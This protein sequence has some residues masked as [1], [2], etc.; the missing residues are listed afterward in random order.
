[1][2]LHS[3]FEGIALGLVNKKGKVG[4][5]AVGF[6]IHKAAEAFSVGS[7]VGQYP[8]KLRI[9]IIGI[10]QTAL[11]TGVLLG[12][13]VSSSNKVVDSVFFSLSAGMLTYIACSEIIVHEFAKPELQPLKFILVGIGMIGVS[14][15]A[16]V[17]THDHGDGHSHG[18]H[19][20]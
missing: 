17:E 12:M 11:T 6:M 18:S 1:M 16:M 7:A 8:L 14:G 2:A 4:S 5:I 19:G 10:L 15:L 3:V 9:T 13:L 20:H